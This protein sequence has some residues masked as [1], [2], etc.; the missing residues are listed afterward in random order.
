MKR[1]EIAVFCLASV[2]F[3]LLWWAWR[4]HR[5]EPVPYVAGSCEARCMARDASCASLMSSQ[6]G[7]PAAELPEHERL[8]LCNGLCFVLRAKNPGS[9]DACLAQ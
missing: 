1:P 9:T 3:L 7:A 8:A 6:G 5:A 2:A 4:N